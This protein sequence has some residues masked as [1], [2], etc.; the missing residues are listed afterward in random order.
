M[1]PKGKTVP[2]FYLL[3]F[4]YTVSM[5]QSHNPLGAFSVFTVNVKNQVR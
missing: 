1:I 2:I 3:S 5:G 4:I